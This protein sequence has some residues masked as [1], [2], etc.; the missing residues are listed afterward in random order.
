MK[1]STKLAILL[2]SDVWIAN[3]FFQVEFQRWYLAP[4]HP[5][6]TAFTASL[7]HCEVKVNQLGSVSSAAPGTVLS[8]HSSS[9]VWLPVGK[10]QSGKQTEL[11]Q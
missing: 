4:T 6:G 7:E 9:W 10:K 2:I 5:A 11:Q 3:M 8:A 1:I